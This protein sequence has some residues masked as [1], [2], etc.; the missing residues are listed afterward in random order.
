MLFACDQKSSGGP[1]GNASSAPSSA[2]VAS[3]SATADAGAT[4]KAPAGDTGSWTGTYTSK[5]AT[6]PAPRKADDDGT[7]GVGD[8][9]VTLTLAEDK[10]A[11]GT[12]GGALGD[13]VLTGTSSGDT[14]SGTLFPKEATPTS[15][16]GTWVLTKK[17]G[18]FTG[19]IVASRGNAGA[20][21]EADLTLKGK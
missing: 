21:R 12:L 16:Y 8:G 19:K 7:Q 11:K 14:M 6:T 1:A 17:D 4:A 18:A 20:V 2:P 10:T 15:F 9:P 5:Q 13:S 3:S